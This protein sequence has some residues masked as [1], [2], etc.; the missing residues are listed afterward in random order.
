MAVP[1]LIAIVSKLTYVVDSLAGPSSPHPAPSPPSIETTTDPHAHGLDYTDTFSPIIKA[2]TIRVVFS[3]AVTNKWPLQQLDIKNAFLN[4]TLIEYVYMEQPLGRTDTSLFVFHQQ[5]GIIYLL[6]YVDDIIITGNNSSLLD[7]F[8]R[9]LHS[10]FDTK[11]LGSFS[12]FFCLEAL[13][14]LDGLF[15]SQLK[16]VQDILT[17]AQ[18]LDSKH[19][20]TPMVHLGSH[21][22]VVSQ[23]LSADGPPFS[24]PTLYRS[25]V[26]ALQYLIITSSDI[27]H[28]VNSISQF[29]HTPTADHFLAGK[30]ILL[31]VK[32][33]LHF[34]LTFCPS[35]V[36]S[37]LVAYSDADWAGCPDTHRSTSGHSIYLGDKL[38]SRSVKKQHTVS[39]SSYESEYRAL[40]MTAT[41]LL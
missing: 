10:E 19:V 23:H 6:L 3:L 30:H 7:S 29:Q 35:V 36:P 34:G 26:G 21:H 15:I 14:T 16:F 22:I 20:H 4:G 1:N 25:L 32:G 40:T 12:Y 24:D 27:A 41:E 38:V 28:A 5:S 13:P 9:K 39:R 11:D 33:T 8:T 17:R 18:L 31:Y 2:T 37:T